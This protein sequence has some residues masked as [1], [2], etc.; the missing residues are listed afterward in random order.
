VTESDKLVLV[1]GE[2]GGS[3]KDVMRFLIF[4]SLPGRR[5]I[6]TGIHW[7]SNEIR[8]VRIVAE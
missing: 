4:S 6:H 1:L 5:L 2:A 8:A 3:G 7:D